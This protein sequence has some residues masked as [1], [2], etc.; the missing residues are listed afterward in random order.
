[1][2]GD[3]RLQPQITMGSEIDSRPVNRLSGP[4]PFLESLTAKGVSLLTASSDDWCRFGLDPG[5]PG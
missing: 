1:M 3:A 4:H 5:Q 2:A